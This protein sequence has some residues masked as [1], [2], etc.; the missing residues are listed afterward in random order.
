MELEIDVTQADLDYWEAQA[1]EL[2][3]QTVAEF[4]PFLYSDGDFFENVN[5]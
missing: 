1:A 3:A 4:D 5:D 2:D